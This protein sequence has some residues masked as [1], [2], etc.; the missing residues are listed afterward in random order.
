MKT[1]DASGHTVVAPS[2]TS[3]KETSAELEL[4]ESR[5]PSAGSVLAQRQLNRALLARQLLLQRVAMPAEQAIEHLV[6]MQSQ[7]PVHP[8]IGLWS[9]VQN[10]EPEELS[11]LMIERRVTRVPLM[12]ATIHLATARDTLALRAIMQE[13][14]ERTFP[15]IAS[16]G[17]HVAGMDMDALLAAGKAHVEQE[18]RT[19]AQLAKLLADQWPDRDPASMSQAI[20]YMLPVV[21]VPPRGVWGKSHQATWTTIEHWLGAPVDGTTQPDEAIFRYLAAF[22]PATVADMQTWSRLTGL[23]AHVERLRS[24]LVTYRNERGQE[25]FDVPEGT[26]ADPETPAPVRFL[27]GFDNLLLSHAERTRIIA[28]DHRTS[29][30]TANGAF[31]ATFLI[32]GFAGG[33]WRI[34]RKR[35]TA[36]LALSPFAPLS[37]DL[38]AALLEEAE[39]FLQFMAPEAT[40][41]EVEARERGTAV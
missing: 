3:R 18:P 22:G 34:T 17:P 35:R 31:E 23:R 27:P 33:T 16:F 4:P 11:R 20:K 8:F 29:L 10:F 7:V 14:Y 15:R 2:L 1:R 39:R 9:R 28:D 37:A 25:L 36:S 41:K 38:K 30:N 6:G 5:R 26:F 13:F 21:Q 12:R 19:G 32:D 24:R 40:R